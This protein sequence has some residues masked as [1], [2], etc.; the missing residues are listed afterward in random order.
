MTYCW[1][2]RLPDSHPTRQLWAEAQRRGWDLRARVLAVLAERPLNKDQLCDRLTADRYPGWSLQD[3]WDQ[4]DHILNDLTLDGLVERVQQEQALAAGGALVK[5]TDTWW[6]WWMATDAV[7]KEAGLALA[8]K[9]I[10]ATQHEEG[11]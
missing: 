2:Y 6:S 1:G 5:G 10:R 4:L 9:V 8:V 11:T 7:Q 3:H